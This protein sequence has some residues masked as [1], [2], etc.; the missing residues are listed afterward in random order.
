MKTTNDYHIKKSL[1]I[2]SL[3]FIIGCQNFHH[4]VESPE[5]VN[6]TVSIDKKD[7]ISSDILTAEQQAKLTPHEVLERLKKGN[8][9]FVEDNLTIRN[10]TERVRKASLGQYPKAVVLSC[11]DSRVPVEDVFHSGI[12]NLFVARVA[13]NVVNDD[14]LGS[15]EYACKVSGAK[16][17]LVLGH[18]YCGAIKSAI[19]D[20]KLGN[21]TTLLDKIQPAVKEARLSFK[22]EK[23]ASN[24]AFVEA[25][26]D[27]N[28]RLAIDQ[29]H[30]RSSIL[31]EME[32][33]GEIL[34]AG[35][36]YNMKTG[37][38]EFFDSK[39]TTPNK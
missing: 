8:K 7:I 21:I 6:E 25:V 10:T 31:K 38:V 24:E 5:K 14:I 23:T 33:K 9:A 11:L 13:G 28:V 35:G 32:E 20:V 30:Q 17:V 4:V 1:V 12:G 29:I 26:C 3:F 22:G 39:K 15:L 27:A 16:L 36:V 19:S 2:I 18:E 34:I 37:E